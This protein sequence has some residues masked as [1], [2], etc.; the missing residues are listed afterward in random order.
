[1][2][3]E[4]REDAASGRIRDLEAELDVARDRIASL[5]RLIRQERAQ[6]LLEQRRAADTVRAAGGADEGTM[7]ALVRAKEEIKELSRYKRQVERLERS[8][9]YGP[10]HRLWS[11]FRSVRGYDQKV[12]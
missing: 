2:D 4:V 5:E 7:K 3:A 1:M 11:R 9:L 6:Y 10:A 12:G 8:P